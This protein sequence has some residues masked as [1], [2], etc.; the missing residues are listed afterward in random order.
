MILLINST[1]HYCPQLANSFRKSARPGTKARS[2]AAPT[3]TMDS[4]ACLQ[5]GT[6]KQ[7]GRRSCCA[8]GGAWFKNCGDTGDT[9]FGHTWAEGIH[10]CKRK[11]VGQR[12]RFMH[13]IVV[14][15]FCVVLI[16]VF[17]YNS[18]CHDESIRGN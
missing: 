4:L 3:S 18:R 14:A 10:A 13:H 1:W 12:C 11:Q 7:S 2:F 5:C 8:P 15:I 17:L 9:K 16:P 6:A